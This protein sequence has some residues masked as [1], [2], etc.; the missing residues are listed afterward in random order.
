MGARPQSPPR[1][2]VAGVGRRGA[3]VRA[4]R[5]DGLAFDPKRARRAVVAAI[6]LLGACMA[7]PIP[8]DAVP[9]CRSAHVDPAALRSD[10]EAL[11][12][13]FAPRDA[14]HPENLARAAAFVA[15]ALRSA[16][17]EVSEQSYRAADRSYRNVLAEVGPDTPE[18]IVIGAH[19]DTAGDQPG[20]DDDAS[21]V[22]GLLAAPVR[23]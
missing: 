1:A 21:G 16:G 6:P 12:T 22:A 15:D 4:V 7:G 5:R 23:A 19:Y 20:A 18:R 11:V 9:P 14:D 3:T 8:A 13:R 10:V 17:A 2:I